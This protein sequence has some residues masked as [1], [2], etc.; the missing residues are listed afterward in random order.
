MHFQ[1]R[2]RR[3]DRGDAVNW[4]PDWRSDGRTDCRQDRTTQGNGPSLMRTDMLEKLTSK[5]GC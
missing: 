3:P 1:Q 2:A 4:Y 5:T